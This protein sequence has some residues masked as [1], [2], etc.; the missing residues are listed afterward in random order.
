M[1]QHSVGSKL[2]TVSVIFLLTILLTSCGYGSRSGEKPKFDGQAKKPDMPEKVLVRDDN[3]PVLSIKL[4]DDMLVPAPLEMSDP[5]PDVQVN[6]FSAID[7]TAIEAFRLLLIDKG[8]AISADDMAGEVKVN[9]TNYSGKLQDV[10]ERISETAGVFYTYRKGLLRLSKDRS[11]IMPLPPIAEALDEMGT[12]IAGLG[13]TDVKIDKSS[14]M[15]TFRATAKA[16]D[17]VQAYME[18]LRNQKVMIVYETYFLEVSLND[19]KKIGINWN[20]ITTRATGS[21]G[22]GSGSGSG[23]SSD[24]TLISETIENTNLL[25]PRALGNG[26]PA[27]NLVSSSALGGA[28]LAFGSLFTSGSLN[29]NVL[30]DFLS[31]QGNVETLSKPTITMMSGGKSKF[32][33]GRKI[34]FVSRRGIASTEGVST[35]QA[36]FE[37]EDLSTGLKVE[38]AGDYSDDTV[39]TNV[40][41]SLDDLI[42]F[43]DP[44]P[45]GQNSVQ[46]PETA[47]RS[48]NTAVRVRPGDSILIAGINQT[49]DTKKAEGPFSF[50]NFFPFLRSKEESV[51]RSELVIVLRPRIVE[52]SRDTVRQEF[53]EKKQAIVAPKEDSLAKKE[54]ARADQVMMFTPPGSS[55]ST[56]GDRYS[57]SQ[58][59]SESRDPMPVMPVGQSPLM[60]VA[61]PPPAMVMP[62][63]TLPTSPQGMQPSAPQM[64]L[65]PKL[66]S[67]P[68]SSY[69]T[70]PTY[71]NAMINSARPLVPSQLPQGR[72]MIRDTGQPFPQP[73]SAQ[74]VPPPMPYSFYAPSP[75]QAPAMPQQQVA[76]SGP[77]TA[78]D[79]Y[80]AG[81]SDGYA[82]RERLTGKSPQQAAPNTAGRGFNGDPY[83]DRFGFYGQSRK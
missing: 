56:S 54:L 81:N 12:V 15:I 73:P 48:L 8:I 68:V 31:Q 25:F 40:T 39:Y 17:N 72:T 29:M 47:T 33:V 46:L 35:T 36:T 49:R 26:T 79:T 1:R 19:A 63:Y 7:A 67:V 60:P 27:L 62:N 78:Q 74:P 38:I 51:D 82:V 13:A 34:R 41:L 23:S 28:G 52:F 10:M 14:R 69:Y 3:D 45:G 80:V 43:T 65:P 9:I 5:L 42:R 22:S 76:N 50:G 70:P 58:R 55:S 24:S 66:N 44:D 59:M 11:F 4:G 6:N 21:S 32:E 20:Q 77:I 16:F 71:N 61:S 75:V 2:F 37:T 30:F 83:A 53:M 57:R 18:R 64:G